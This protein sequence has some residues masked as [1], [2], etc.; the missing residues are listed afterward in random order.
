MPKFKKGESGNPEGRP[1]GSQ[2][3]AT[4]LMASILADVPALLEVT[5]QKAFAGDMVAMRLLLERVLPVSKA[6]APTIA[7]PALVEAHTLTDKAN[8]I[9]ATVANGELPSDMAAQLLGSLSD[10]AKLVELES[11]LKRVEL[12][13]QG[14]LGCHK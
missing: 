14:Q 5:K 3:F 11:L 1:K 10:I 2:N 7:L 13:E 4:K 6:T 9:L 12:L 8:A